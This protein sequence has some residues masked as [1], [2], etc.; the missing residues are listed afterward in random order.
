MTKVFYDSALVHLRAVILPWMHYALMTAPPPTPPAPSLNL[1][2]TPQWSDSSGRQ[3]GT[4][5]GGP[6]AGRVVL[7]AQLTAQHQQKRVNDP[8][9]DVDVNMNIATQ[10]RWLDRPGRNCP[11]RGR[12]GRESTGGLLSLHHREC[13]AVLH[14]S[15]ACQLFS[16]RQKSSAEGRGTAQEIISCPRSSLENIVSSRQGEENHCRTLTPWTGA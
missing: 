14:H 12:Y 15:A 9:D 1:P 5:G 4:Q 16:G 10:Q 3:D 7:P 2:T 6:E 8:E 11:S 13:S